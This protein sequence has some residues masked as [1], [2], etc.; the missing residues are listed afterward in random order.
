M[1]RN[2]NKNK[3]IIY[4]IHELAIDVILLSYSHFLQ[5]NEIN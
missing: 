4:V 1:I 5:K 2:V 3:Q